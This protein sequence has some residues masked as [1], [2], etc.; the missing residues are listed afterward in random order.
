[1]S[2]YYISDLHFGHANIMKFDN[3]PFNSVEEMN[4]ALIDNWNSVVTDKDTVMIL[5]DFCWG[6]EDEWISILNKLRGTKQLILGN[7]DHLRISIQLIHRSHRLAGGP[8]QVHKAAG[9]GGCFYFV[10]LHELSQLFRIFA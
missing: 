1:M 3:R 5:G 10:R 6:L 8:A 7:H 4:K 9:G 2:I